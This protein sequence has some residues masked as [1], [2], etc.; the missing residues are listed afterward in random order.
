[1]VL[2]R[3]ARTP[4][5]CAGCA[6][7]RSTLFRPALPP[8]T[9]HRRTTRR[10]VNTR[11]SAGAR[12]RA[13]SRSRSMVRADRPVI[14]AISAMERPA[15]QRMSTSMCSSGESLASAFTLRRRLAGRRPVVTPI[16]SVSRKA[17]RSSFSASVK[18]IP[19][20]WS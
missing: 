2:P 7:Q 8:S 20:R 6:L 14:S 10:C 4:K 1:M 17:T 5:S 9:V 12:P 15:K 16:Y 3:T 11:P 13:F 19:K 18:P